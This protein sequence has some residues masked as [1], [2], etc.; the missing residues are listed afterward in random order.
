MDI[1]YLNVSVGNKPGD[2]PFLRFFAYKSLKWFYCGHVR[3]TLRDSD[4]YLKR[5]VV[6]IMNAYS[7]QALYS[8]DKIVEI[9][10]KRLKEQN[11]TL[12][13]QIKS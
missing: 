5:L 3:R 13:L 12:Y 10:T 8:G 6:K 7:F 11:S 2:L 1:T 4:L 9:K